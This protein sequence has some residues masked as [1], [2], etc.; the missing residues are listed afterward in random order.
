MS[1]EMC[2]ECERCG[3]ALADKGLAFICLRMYLLCALRG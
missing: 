2:T 3:A 1:L